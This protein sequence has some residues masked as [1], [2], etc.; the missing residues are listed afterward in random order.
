[1]NCSACSSRLAAYRDGDLSRA[2][3]RLVN[4]HLAG[5]SACTALDARMRR[6]D[7]ALTRIVLIEPA[8]D[9]TATIMAKIAALPSPAR[10]RVVWPWFAAYVFA[11]WAVVALLNALH[12]VNISAI[13][14]RVGGFAGQAGVALETLSRLGGHFHVADVAAIAVAIEIILLAVAATAGRKYLPRLGSALLG[15]RS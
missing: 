8:P 13:I 15:A 3:A 2:D 4:E 9:F 1:V 10:R 5:C 12:V 14:G 7:T 11:T 6:V